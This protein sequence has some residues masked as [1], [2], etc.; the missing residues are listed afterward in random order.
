MRDPLREKD[1]RLKVYLAGPDAFFPNARQIGSEKKR[2]CEEYG[3][4]GLFPLDNERLTVGLGKDK[5]AE[6]IF[7]A[8]CE[9]MDAAHLL[10]ANMMPFRGVSADAGTAFELGYMYA[11]GKPVFG[12]GGDGLTYLE[13][14]LRADLGTRSDAPHDRR[15]MRIEDL[16]LTDNLMLVCAVRHYGL[17]IGYHKGELSDLSAFR[18]CVR[19]AAERLPLLRVGS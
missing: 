13:R 19:F 18:Q 12:Y 11:Q 1:R 7:R 2:I 5:A 6:G 14:V 3:F 17:D 16:D 4:E 9:A 15:G 8:N 10:I